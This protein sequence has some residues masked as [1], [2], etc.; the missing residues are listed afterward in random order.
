MLSELE[1]SNGDHARKCTIRNRRNCVKTAGIKP[2][3][4]EVAS[5]SCKEG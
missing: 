4:Y 3:G 5:A 1:V 2:A